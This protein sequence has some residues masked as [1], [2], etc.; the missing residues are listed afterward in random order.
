MK[1]R[2][3]LTEMYSVFEAEVPLGETIDDGGFNY[4]LFQRISSYDRIVV[5]GQAKSHCVKDS[6]R[7]L[8]KKLSRAKRKEVYLL[9]DCTSPVKSCEE[10]GEELERYMESQGAHVTTTDELTLSEEE[11][12]SDADDTSEE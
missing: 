4:E 11:E 3:A 10:A 1:G 6:V 7:S 8:L 5:A 2:N 9:K 12:S